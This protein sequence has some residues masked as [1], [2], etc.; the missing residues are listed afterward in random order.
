MQEIKILVATHKAYPLPE[1]TLYVPIQVGGVQ[2]PGMEHALRDDTG[3]N[4]SAKNKSYCEMTA[5]YWGWKNL[6]ADYLGLV[7][8]RRYFAGT[9]FAANKT[10]R[11]ASRQEIE[12]E[13]QKAPVILPKK[14]NYWIETTYTQYAHAH[15]R[16]DLDLVR[17]ILT[18][19]YPEYVCAFDRVMDRTAGHR[20]NMFLMR[21]DLLDDYCAWLFDVLFRAEKHIDVSEYDDYNQ[22]VFGFLSERLLDVWIET[23][24]VPYVEM[25]VVFM[26][27]QHWLKKGTAFI[28]RKFRKNWM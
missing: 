11:I 20:F 18:E 5:L 27:S 28:R 15:H 12:A 3:D 16:K 24:Q 26:E 9:H 1:G 17:T 21:R 19:Q 22:R 2:I 23:N 25:P 13:L 4:I 14:R 8:Y 10:K 6:E 7:H